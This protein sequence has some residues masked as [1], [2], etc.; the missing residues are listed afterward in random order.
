MKPSLIA[1]I[2]VAVALFL[3]PQAYAVDGIFDIGCDYSHSLP[4]DPIMFPGDPGA[5]HLHD[6]FGFKLTDAFSTAAQMLAALRADP[7]LTTCSEQGDPKENPAENA[8]AYWT[9]AAY[10][11]D[12]RIYPNHVHIYYR[13]PGRRECEPFPTGFKVI[14]GD[15]DAPPEDQRGVVLWYCRNPGGGRGGLE[16]LPPSC[17]DAPSIKGQVISASCWNGE[18]DSSDHRSHVA[19]PDEKSNCPTSHPR[20]LPRL[21]MDFS[22]PVEDQI[23]RKINPRHDVLTLETGPMS[24]FH[25]DYLSAWKPKRLELL[26]EKC[27]NEHRNCKRDPP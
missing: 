27:L 24:T 16:D 26:V 22:Y 11:N 12:Q 25:A 8:S 19:Y 6:F 3:T 10:W 15:P 5:S 9:P 17:K 14:I 4:D 7:F 23:G 2:A 18:L 20:K 13:C 21:T 1:F